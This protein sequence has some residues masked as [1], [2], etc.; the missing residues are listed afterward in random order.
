MQPQVF[1]FEGE[2]KAIWARIEQLEGARVE[3]T[4]SLKEQKTVHF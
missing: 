4:S 2:I 3:H 1:G